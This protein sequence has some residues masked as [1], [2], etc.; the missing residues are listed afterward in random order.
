MEITENGLITVIVGWDEYAVME[1][2][3]KAKHDFFKR[4]LELP[5]GIPNEKTFARVFSFVNPHEL[6]AC[7]HQ[8]LD[9]AKGP[10]GREINIGRK[11]ISGSAC[12]SLGKRVSAWVGAKNLV[13]GQLA[14][15]EK[16]R[17]NSHTSAIG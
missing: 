4:F 10:G 2:F 15:D 5:N 1:D 7:L 9:E 12:K 17:N 8:W 3:G 13:L 16:Q 11:T 6:T 14:A